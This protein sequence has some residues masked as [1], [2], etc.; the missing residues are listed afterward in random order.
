MFFIP[1][2]WLETSIFQY[3]LGKIIKTSLKKNLKIT[4]YTFSTDMIKI[5]PILKI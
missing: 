1:V 2:E 3:A 4:I 5:S